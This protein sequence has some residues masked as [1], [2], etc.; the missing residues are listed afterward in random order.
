MAPPTSLRI[1][2][3]D[4]SA[5]MRRLL[6]DALGRSGFTVVARTIPSPVRGP[7]AHASRFRVRPKSA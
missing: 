4:D 5:F 2:V 3:A 7:G 6:T 1:V